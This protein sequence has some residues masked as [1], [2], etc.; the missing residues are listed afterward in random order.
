M[1]WKCEYCGRENMGNGCCIHC[2]APNPLDDY[3]TKT[4]NPDVFMDSV[5][6]SFVD[7]VGY[8]ELG[9]RLVVRFKSGS[10]YEYQGV[11]K[12]IYF[13]FMEDES[14]G[15]FYSKHIRGKYESNLL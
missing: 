15:R 3:I 12:D 14:K 9:K 10:I 1:I 13:G 4:P 11:P 2:S 5:E 6:S 8:D 7:S